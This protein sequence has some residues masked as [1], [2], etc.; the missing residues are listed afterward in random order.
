MFNS[1][2]AND[3]LRGQQQNYNLKEK[4]QHTALEV[5]VKGFRWFSRHAGGRVAEENTL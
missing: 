5:K 3:C 2:C 1:K 4:Y